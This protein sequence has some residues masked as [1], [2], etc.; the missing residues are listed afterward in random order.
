MQEE[1]NAF[2]ANGTWKLTKIPKDC[3]SVGCKWM[4]HTKKDVLNNIV[5]YKTQLIAKG[6]F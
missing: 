1:Y 3:K 4:F 6:Y 2:T 5:R